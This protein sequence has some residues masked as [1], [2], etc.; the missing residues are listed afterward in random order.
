MAGIVRYDVL[1]DGDSVYTGP[2]RSARLAYDTL[3][4]FSDYV[5]TAIDVVADSSDDPSFK[6]CCLHIKNT[7][8]SIV[9]AFH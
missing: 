2:I 8:P 6:E 9:L 5:K 3:I 4:S 1:V 7:L